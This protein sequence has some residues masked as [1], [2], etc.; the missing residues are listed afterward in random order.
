MEIIENLF[1]GVWNFYFKNE[2]SINYPALAIT[3]SMLALSSA[4][5]WYYVLSRSKLVIKTTYRAQFAEYPGGVLGRT[6]PI[7]S[8]YITNKSRRIIVIKDIAFKLNTKLNN[9]DTF[10][11]INRS[12]PTSYPIRLDPSDQYIYDCDMISL[13]E[14]LFKQSSKIKYFKVLAKD[15]LNK[16][17]A[18]K[19]VQVKDFI[20]NMNNINGTNSRENKF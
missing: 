19:K 3:I 18:S 8:A 14:V 5:F 12:K 20:V 17:Y 11:H 7:F 9:F 16:K 1:N 6:V 10:H 4:L 13:N 2:G 15:T